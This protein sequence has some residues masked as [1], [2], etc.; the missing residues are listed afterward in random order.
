MQ[1]FLNWLKFLSNKYGI[2]KALI[3]AIISATLIF[4]ILYGNSII[5]FIQYRENR[6][7]DL[8]LKKELYRHKLLIMYGMKEHELD[9]LQLNNKFRTE[10]V[11]DFFRCA[12]DTE[13]NA[14]EKLLSE[15]IENM[16]SNELY[17]K[18][19]NMVR[20]SFD[21]TDKCLL[22]D[23]NMDHRLVVMLKKIIENDVENYF[24]TIKSVF[25]D[26]LKTDKMYNV[27][28]LEKLMDI[29]EKRWQQIIIKIQYKIDEKSSDEFKNIKYNNLNDYSIDTIK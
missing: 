7:A 27:Y 26:N 13:K 11:K 28:K 2:F 16:D 22:Q 24:D 8:P 17:Q 23:K 1:D 6:K 21:E 4:G 15:D 3:V 29:A 19:I 18:V 9:V 14:V 25:D 20:V 12:F 5:A 10:I